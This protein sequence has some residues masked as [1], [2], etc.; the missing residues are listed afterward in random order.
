MIIVTGGAG[1]IGSNIVRALNEQGHD[2]ILVVDESIDSG[3]AENIS[4][5]TVVDCI[6]KNDFLRRA[7][8]D[9]EFGQSDAIFHE[10][11]CSDT[12]NTIIFRDGRNMNTRRFRNSHRE[13]RLITN[14]LRILLPGSKWRSEL[15]AIRFLNPGRCQPVS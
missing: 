6:E 2:K 3:K 14:T 5:L 11:A 15:S 7:Q 1:F 4:D 12:T 9:E 10:G 8:K 13:L